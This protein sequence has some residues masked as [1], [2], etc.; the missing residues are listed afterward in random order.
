[1]IS[2]HW[3]GRTKRGQDQAYIAP[4][5]ADTFP[6][7][8]AIPGF[9]SASILKRDGPDG[10]EFEMVTVWQSRRASATGCC[11]ERSNG[12]SITMLLLKRYLRSFL[13]ERNR[14]IKSTA[15]SDGWRRYLETA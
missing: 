5:K 11:A 1:M 3:R 9:V 15:E 6:T 4:L 2:R 7:I 10:S 13:V 14:V 12:W 8:S